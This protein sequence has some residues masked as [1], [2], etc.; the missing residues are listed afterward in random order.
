MLNDSELNVSLL[1]NIYLYKASW[2]FVVYVVILT[3]ICERYIYIYLAHDIND[4]RAPNVRA[5]LHWI[6]LSVKTFEKPK[7]WSIIFILF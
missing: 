7:R 2:S 3:C 4:F 6:Y 1:I 5:H